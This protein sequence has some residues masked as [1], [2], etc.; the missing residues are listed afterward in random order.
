MVIVDPNEMATADNKNKV[1]TSKSI[2]GTQKPMNIQKAQIEFTNSST[3][4]QSQASA[5]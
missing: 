2:I 1:Y 4:N 5:S 3:K